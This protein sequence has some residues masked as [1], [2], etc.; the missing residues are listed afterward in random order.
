MKS[1][2]L[3][4]LTLFLSSSYYII[5]QDKLSYEPSINPLIEAEKAINNEAFEDALKELDKVY[6]GDSLF[7]RYAV[8]MR[9]KTYNAME[10]YQSAKEFG[11][12]YWYFRH[13]LPT[14]FYL[15]YGAA[16]DKLELY[17]EAQSMY[18]SILEEF[19]IN[20]SLWY[21]L[22]VSLALSGNHQ[23]S[24]EA[25]KR[26]VEINP[27]YDRA[28]LNLAVM[29]M[30]E[31]QTSR[32]LMALGM[33][34]WL[35]VD[36]RNNFPQLR[37]ADYIASSKYWTDDDFSGSNGVDLGDNAPYEII[38]QLVHNYVATR[39]K[40]KTPSKL[41]Y[42]FINQCHLIFTQFETVKPDEEDFWF[43]TYS[44][45]YKKLI[46]EKKF[47]GYT[48]L[49]SNFIENESIAKTVKK[50]Q[51]E[52]LAFYEWA[53]KTLD[54]L[55]STVDLEIDD[56]TKV[57]VIRNPKS[58]FIQLFGDFE[59]I[60]GT[61][62]L[63]GRIYAV[64]DEGR[65]SAKGINNNQGN[66]HGE[67]KYYHNNGYL[68]EREKF[69][70]GVNIDT[71]YLYYSNGF[72]RLKIGFADGKADGDIKFFNNGVLNKNLPYQQGELGDGDYI[73][74]HPIG[75][76][77]VY[78]KLK[79]GKAN[80]DYKEYFI[81]GE[82]YREGTFE[83]GDLSAKRI[84]YFRNGS[85]S[86]EEHFKDGKKHGDY[87]S[88]YDDGV[89]EG[90]GKYDEGKQVGEWKNYY[91]NGKLSKIQEFDES[92]KEN[93]TEKNYTKEGWL[94]SEIMYK[95]GEIDAYKYFDKE[96][97]VLS[98]GSRKGGNL[99]YQSHFKNGNKN[100]VGNYNKKGYDG[101]WTY[102][103]FN[104]TPVKVREYKDGEPF[105]TYQEKH[106]NGRTSQEYKFEDGSP[107]GLLVNY[108]RNGNIS[109]Q[110]FLK[111]GYRDGPWVDY[112]KNGTV[113]EEMFY[114]D[115]E[116]QGF[117][118]YYNLRGQPSKSYFYKDGL[119]MFEI[120]YDTAGVAFDTIYNQPGKRKLELS[121]CA[122]CPKF[123]SVDVMNNVYHGNQVFYFPDGQIN[124]KGEMVNG[125]RIGPW[126][127]Y[128]PNGK[129]KSEGIYE[130]GKREGEWKFYYNSGKLEDI[131]NYKS[132]KL[133]GARTSYDEDGKV[134][135][136]ANYYYGDLHGKVNYY[137]NGKVDHTRNY[138]YGYILDY[139]YLSGRDS[140]KQELVNETGE[141]EIKWANGKTARKYKIDKGWF[142][143]AYLKYY[144]SGK[145]YSETNYK[146]DLNHGT[147]KEYFENGKVKF[148]CEYVEG[149]RNGTLV[150]YHKNGKKKTE[151]RYE[152]GNLFGWS[153][154]YKEDGSLL[155]S[156]YYFDDN[157]LDVKLG[158]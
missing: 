35:S 27:F 110:G 59:V 137:I 17:D 141:V 52:A 104:E 125:R 118:R 40:Y 32:A 84:T 12:K 30:N 140:V 53:N 3:L 108:Y 54:E 75:T 65:I 103:D 129:L 31:K 5:S 124:A 15:A 116:L 115:R 106:V 73:E 120:R 146:N 111:D 98:E 36:K 112:A 158:A 8:H 121:Y 128:Y 72:L 109:L 95:K 96:G 55:K 85:V 122:T 49:I 114:S 28:H 154:Y 10:D 117:S 69:D 155:Y 68:R 100:A 105:G 76:Q 135:F 34:M 139:T 119:Q 99:A 113:L 25:L 20:H 101:K 19:P 14:E 24:F 4:C 45:F 60:P 47:P 142:E 11:D 39:D 145:L 138:S 6:E 37:L 16:L 132:G 133:H 9:M 43:R 41:S 22:S 123:M 143:G 136:K 93:G 67:W 134:N 83:N 33:Y 48:Y 77:K 157:I 131:Y 79:A 87:I 156:V 127:I 66:K 51:K 148:E 90:E 91:Q 78:H 63:K 97:N 74:Y 58:K 64:T 7:F 38:D 2:F 94:L 61:S 18:R 46:N 70:N 152:F 71:S 23:A 50:K 88:Y 92:G 1:K 82:L 26:T 102:Y 42:P 13:D 126:K 44:S 86:Y 62:D 80:G 153:H 57:N 130:D 144:P 89:L 21:N 81:T 107:T 29:A 151:E 150:E 147:R 56:L 149:Q